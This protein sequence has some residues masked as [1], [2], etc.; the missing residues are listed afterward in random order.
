MR[1]QG[2]YSGTSSGQV[3]CQD[4]IKQIKK[5]VISVSNEYFLLL[6]KSE[7]EQIK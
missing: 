1:S 3:L 2:I 6:K 5:K 4:K 7:S